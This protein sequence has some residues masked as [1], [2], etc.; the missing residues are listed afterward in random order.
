MIDVTNI[1]VLGAHCR[2]AHAWK[3]QGWS[4]VIPAPTVHLSPPHSYVDA[5]LQLQR[6]NAL[7]SKLKAPFSI[8]FIGA[9]LAL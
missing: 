6:I 7:L 9:D 1:Y 8:M 4:Q 3:G 2:G 5:T